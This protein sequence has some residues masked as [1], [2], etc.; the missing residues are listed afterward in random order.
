VRGRRVAK[1]YDR[2]EAWPSIN[3]TIFSKH[4]IVAVALVQVK[5]VWESIKQSLFACILFIF[6]FMYIKYIR[7]S[8]NYIKHTF[9][10]VY[11][12]RYSHLRF[13]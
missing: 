3:N 12:T 1:S 5:I 13:Q 11:N 4:Y 8:Y 6:L 2:D 9:N 7:K 10:F